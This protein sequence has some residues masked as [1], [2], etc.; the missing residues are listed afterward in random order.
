MPDLS[1]TF[2]AMTPTAAS[3]AAASSTAGRRETSQL[4]T[5]RQ[6]PRHDHRDD[7]DQRVRRLCRDEQLPLPDMAELSDELAAARSHGYCVCRTFQ[8][9]R[10][11]VAAAIVG[12]DGQPVGALSMAGP[13]S[14]FPPARLAAIGGAV[15]EAARVASRRLQVAGGDPL[16]SRPHRIDTVL[17][18]RG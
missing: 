3:S 11:S 7:A 15:T 16:G 12:S 18:A 14:T 10:T 17:D 2:R 8:P 1:H 9:G 13:N 4:A 6:V 5:W